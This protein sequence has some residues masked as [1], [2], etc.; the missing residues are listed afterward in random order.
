ML[1]G[2]SIIV[3]GAAQGI[4]AVMAAGFAEMGAQVALSDINDAGV[5]A[6]RING[7]GALRSRCRRM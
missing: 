3:T 7:A 6:E 5:A 2:K 1:N 4:G